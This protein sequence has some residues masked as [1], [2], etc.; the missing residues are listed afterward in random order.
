MGQ[1]KREMKQRV[2]RE[3]GI[4]VGR[5]EIRDHKLHRLDGKPLKPTSARIF[6]DFVSSQGRRKASARNIRKHAERR[7]PLHV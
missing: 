3:E 7:W 6:A 5:L 2:A 4:P 1:S